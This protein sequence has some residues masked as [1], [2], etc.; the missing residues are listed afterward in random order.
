MT[1]T[2]R[3]GGSCLPSA[4]TKVMG[5]RFFAGSSSSWTS[6]LSLLCVGVVDDPITSSRLACPA[7]KLLPIPPRLSKSS[8]SRGFF[9][10]GSSPRASASAFAFS[11]ANAA[12][13]TLLLAGS[14]PAAL[15]AGSAGFSDNFGDLGDFGRRSGLAA[16]ICCKFSGRIASWL[17]DSSFTTILP[18]WEGSLTRNTSALQPFSSG[19][20]SRAH[21]LTI[22]VSL[23]ATPATVWLSLGSLGLGIGDAL[24]SWSS[25]ARKSS[26]SSVLASGGR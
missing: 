25:Q 23:K 4:A 17:P 2:L 21:S 5:S 1:V 18:G 14:G 20:F 7:G 8:F 26:K 13:K 15:L 19:L 3:L 12:P 9:L 24:F 6:L 16:T 22:S 11:L 10:S